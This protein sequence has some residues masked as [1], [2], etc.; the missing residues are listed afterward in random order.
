MCHNLMLTD[1]PKDE[2]RIHYNANNRAL[3]VISRTFHCYAAATATDIF[4][5]MFKR[6]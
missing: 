1:D 3:C 6:F 2:I 4:N 5:I